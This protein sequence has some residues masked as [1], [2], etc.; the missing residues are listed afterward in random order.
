VLG[1]AAV[2][3]TAACRVE[4]GAAVFVGDVRIAETQVDEVVEDLV[5][6]LT[7]EAPEEAQN[8]VVGG[9]RDR[10]VDALTIAELGRQVSANTGDEPDRDVGD[11]HADML[12]QAGF[13]A[14]SRFVEL[15]REAE[16]YRAMLL[17]EAEPVSPDDAD[18]EAIVAQLA[19][20]PGQEL[21]P[22][23]TASLTTFLR[24]DEQG[25]LM[26]GKR[27]A[28]VD[29]VS[30]YDVVANPRYGS[31]FLTVELGNN[32]RPFLTVPISR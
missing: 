11:A 14:D 24:E 5:D 23:Q 13:P 31:S 7:A 16:S 27:Q 25:Q 22:Q 19:V 18:I 20:V 32:G 10:T 12:T 30:E 6:K 4:P 9:L 15:T 8:V 3:S 29:Y 26:S 1:I 21:D 17:A 28:M 2:A